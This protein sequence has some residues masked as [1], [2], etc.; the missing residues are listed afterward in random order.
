MLDRLENREAVPYTMPYNT[1]H[2]ENECSNQALSLLRN[3]SSPRTGLF[4]GIFRQFDAVCFF[5]PPS[6]RVFISKSSPELN[7][8]LAEKRKVRSPS[9]PHEGLIGLGAKAAT[10]LLLRLCSAVI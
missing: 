3:V 4:G 2:H 1:L 9:T 7:P 10:T 6:F 5:Q 8:T